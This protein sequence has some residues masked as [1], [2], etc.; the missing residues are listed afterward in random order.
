MFEGKKDEKKEDAGIK[1][2]IAQEVAEEE[3]QKFVDSWE[4]NLTPK[5]QEEK[6]DIEGLKEKVIDAIKRGRLIVN[7]DETLNYSISRTPKKNGQ[8]IT[9]KRPVGSTYWEVDRYKEQQNAKKTDAVLAAMTNHD[10]QFFSD[11]GGID[12]KPLKAIMMLF[13]AG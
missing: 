4:I 3:F 13:L 12:Q 5:S 2:P 9:I 11:I 7:D 6:I 10:I 1:Y 8:I